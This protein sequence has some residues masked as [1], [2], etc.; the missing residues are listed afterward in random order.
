MKLGKAWL[1]IEESIHEYPRKTLISIISPRKRERYVKQYI[2]QLYIDRYASFTEKI[3]YKKNQKSCPYPAK[4][5]TSIF[6]Y[7]LTCGHNPTIM[8]YYCC[9]LKLKDGV[10]E[11]TFKS[12]RKTTEDS[13]YFISEISHKIE[14]EID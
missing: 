5:A 12:L 3:A 11:Y 14:I 6:P 1:I 7:I 9:K 2:E 13:G 8:A 4:R 10:L